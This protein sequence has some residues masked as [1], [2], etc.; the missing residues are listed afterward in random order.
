[1]LVFCTQSAELLVYSTPVQQ[2]CLSIA[3]QFS[4]VACL[5][6]TSSAELLVYSTPVQ[7]SGLSIA[8]QFSR[9]ACLQHTSSAEL[10][11]YSTPVQQSGLSIA[12]QFS[13]VACLQHTSSAEL[14]VCSTPL[15]PSRQHSQAAAAGSQTRAP[16]AKLNARPL[17]S[18]SD[19]SSQTTTSKHRFPTAGA[20][21]NE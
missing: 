13:R 4:R 1:M 3:H 20:G 2:S 14:L 12:H 18:L 21:M 19:R 8:H 5:Q 6:H 10:L 17:T 11:V 7:Q 16:T 15:E 9:V